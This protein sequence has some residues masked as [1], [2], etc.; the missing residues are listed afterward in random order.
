VAAQVAHHEADAENDEG[1]PEDERS[2]R[3]GEDD[4]QA[5]NMTSAPFRRPV[6]AAAGRVA[7]RP[8]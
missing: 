1:A 7:A 6:R 3:P 8:S 4:E 5:W 2:L